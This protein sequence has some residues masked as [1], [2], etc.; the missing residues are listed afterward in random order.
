MTLNALTTKSSTSLIY[1][2]NLLTLQVKIVEAAAISERDIW[3]MQL[4]DTDAVAS[5]IKQLLRV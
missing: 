5:S 1:I 2:L 3:T 4:T